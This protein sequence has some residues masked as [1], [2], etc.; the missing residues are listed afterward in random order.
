MEEEHAITPIG[1]TDWRDQQHQFGMYDADRLMHIICLGKSGSGKSTL[2]ETMA[3]SD[4]QKGKGV[5]IID[6][7]GDV[8]DHL[9]EYVTEDRRNDVV[10]FNASDTAFPISF[11][12]LKGVRP[13]QRHLVA[14]GLVSTFKKIWSDSWGPR[15]EHI[16]KFSL[17]TLLEY[18]SATLLDI[19]PLLT[20]KSF[21]EGVLKYVET[22]SVLTFWKNEFE[23]LSPY[24][25][26]EVVSPILNKVGVFVSSEPLRLILGQ[27]TRGFRMQEVL[28]GQQILLV[29]IAKGLIGEDASAILGGIILNAIQLAALSRASQPI[30]ERNFIPD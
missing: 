16:L 21:R 9:L 11:N 1:V 24:M 4:I 5:A 27:Q 17:L 7:H 19:A 25:K 26:A 30:H 28:D 18:P 2:L 15:M 14:S 22:P 10:Y 29:N 13:E 8:V 12:P 20:D 23:S 3:I 6:P